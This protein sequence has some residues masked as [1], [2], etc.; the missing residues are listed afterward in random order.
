VKIGK[1]LAKAFFAWISPAPNE[2]LKIMSRSEF[3]WRLRGSCMNR[4]LY[5]W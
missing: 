5:C 4:G 1:I 3:E 2:G